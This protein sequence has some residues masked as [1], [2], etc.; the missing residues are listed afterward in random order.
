MKYCTRCGQK[1]NDEDTFCSNCGM[2][3]GDIIQGE[4]RIKTVESTRVDRPEM[5]G[6]YDRQYGQ[7]Y[8][9]QNGQQNAQYRTQ[10]SG[11]Y[12]PRYNHPNNG[13]QYTYTTR[14]YDGPISKHRKINPLIFVPFIFSGIMLIAA[15]L[16]AFNIR[17]ASTYKGAV[18]HFFNALSSGDNRKVVSVMMPRRMERAANEAARKGDLKAFGYDDLYAAVDDKYGYYMDDNVEIQ[19]AEIAQKEQLNRTYMKEVERKLIKQMDVELVIEDAYDIVAGFDYR[20][21]GSSDWHDE[22]IR[23]ISYKVKGKWYAIPEDYL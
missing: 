13:R 19:K 15:L 4:A 7:Q 10:H 16:I 20:E 14:Q 12:D 11:Q 22:T 5:N 18:N 17:G 6:R 2:P 3:T 9:Q 8:G 21:N 23:F 1:L